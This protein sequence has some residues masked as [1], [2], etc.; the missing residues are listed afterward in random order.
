[1]QNTS[2]QSFTLQSLAGNIYANNIL[3]GNV[4]MFDA[5]QIEANS[6]GNLRLR[7][8]LLLIGVLQTIIDALDGIKKQKIDLVARANVD[9]LQLPID[10][11]YEIG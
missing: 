7:A 1:M 4:A 11:T 10:I 6:Q 2:N 8:S 5:V 3:V 9:N